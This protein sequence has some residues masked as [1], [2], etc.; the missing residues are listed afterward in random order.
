MKFIS[1]RGNINGKNLELENNPAHIKEA[2]KKGYDVEI[3]V[4]FIDTFYLGHDKP[5]YKVTKSFLENTKLW[6]HAKKFV[7]FRKFTKVK[8]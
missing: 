6:C 7:S 5:E 4:W 3:D 1:H 2:I 8:N